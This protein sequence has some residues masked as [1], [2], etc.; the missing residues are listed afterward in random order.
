[1]PYICAKAICATF[2]AHISGALIPLFGPNFPKM[3]I[4]VD[5]PDYGRHVIDSAIIK[6]AAE[7]AETLRASLPALPQGG[8]TSDPYFRGQQQQRPRQMPSPSPSSRG[9]NRF[10]SV[11]PRSMPS[12]F[13][14]RHKRIRIKRPN[15]HIEYQQIDTDTDSGR[16][17]SGY[18]PR[19][20]FQ[21]DTPSSTPMTSPAL[22]YVSSGWTP[23]N[24]AERMKS[25][26]SAFTNNAGRDQR[27]LREIRPFNHNHSTSPKANSW[28]SAVPGGGVSMASAP[29]FDPRNKLPPIQTP[30]SASGRLNVGLGIKTC[31]EPPATNDAKRALDSEADRNGIDEMRDYDADSDSEDISPRA[32]K[33]R[34]KSRDLGCRREEG[35]I[36]TSP[37]RRTPLPMCREGKRDEDT[38]RNAAVLALLSL[39]VED[40]PDG[41]GEGFGHGQGI[42]RKRC[43]SL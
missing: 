40:R 19:P 8:V 3:C 25:N 16:P 30:M 23:C 27:Q 9:S 1:M 43:A 26:M 11:S 31:L 37:A 10:D 35:T 18:P 38:E 39:S 13:E 21:P 29:Q 24:L 4:P 12:E 41:R 42:K 20:H 5:S 28:L 34:M 14:N 7:E 2:C 33:K 17:H 15:G 32:V 36:A 6:R 22:S